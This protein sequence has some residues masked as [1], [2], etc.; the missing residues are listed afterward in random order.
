MTI[1]VNFL[2]AIIEYK[3]NICNY[4]VEVKRMQL[5]NKGRGNAN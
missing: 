2:L 1:G 5:S 3:L 4:M